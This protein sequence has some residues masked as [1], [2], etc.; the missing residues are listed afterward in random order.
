M[1]TNRLNNIESSKEEP[2]SVI[3]TSKE[4]KRITGGIKYQI[5]VVM[6]KTSDASTEHDQLLPNIVQIQHHL[7]RAQAFAIMHDYNG[8][9]TKVGLHEL[10]QA[11]R[12]DIRGKE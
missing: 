11:I 6:A 9:E 10:I 3:I 4:I 5:A 7:T 2:W 1:P 12:N 8:M